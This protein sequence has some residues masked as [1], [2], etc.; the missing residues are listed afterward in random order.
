MGIIFYELNEVPYRVLAHYTA[1]NPDSTIAQ[2]MRHSTQFETTSSDEGILSPWVTWPTVHRGVTNRAHLIGDLGQ[3]LQDVDAEYPPFF[4]ALAKGGVKVGVFG[5][6]HTYPVPKNVENY[7]FYVPDTFASGPETFPEYMQ[8][9]QNFNLKMVDLSG[10]NVSGKIAKKAAFQFMSRLF[11]LGVTP[12]TIARLSQ[13]IFSEIRNSDRKV[14]RRTSQTEIAFDIFFKALKQKQP[15]FAS[16]F[17]NHV[18]SSMHRYWPGLFPDDYDHTAFDSEWLA[19]FSGEIDFTMDVANHQLSQ[20][21]K[22]V[23]KHSSYQLVVLSSMGQAAVDETEIIRTQL[24]ITDKNKFLSYFGLNADQWQSERAMAPRCIFKISDAAALAPLLQQLKETS[25]NGEPLDLAEHAHGV[26]RVK[27]GQSN[28]NSE[29][30]ELCSQGK[31]VALEAMGISNLEIQDATGSY[32]YHI[33]SGSLLVYDPKKSV[34]LAQEAN[35]TQISTC[36]IAP[37]MLSHF[38]VQTPAYMDKPSACLFN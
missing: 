21:V 24:Q 16:F 34:S 9:F 5:S 4:H 33:T 8:V 22:F 37:A 30:I 2:L 28:L 1:Q 15:E 19:R 26:V 36:E 13:Q 20:L 14:R 18:A 32:A 25:I 6:L 11:Q 10:R 3:D 17:T 23:Q 12:K 7:A 27:L 31:K 35:K 38:G 29:E